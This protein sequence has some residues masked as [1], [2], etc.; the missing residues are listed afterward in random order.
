[1]WAADAGTLTGDHDVL[2]E[3]D[4]NVTLVVTDG[5]ASYAITLRDG[6]SPQG[7]WTSNP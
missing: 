4:A 3:A 5:G 6:A 2:V 1:V 7:T